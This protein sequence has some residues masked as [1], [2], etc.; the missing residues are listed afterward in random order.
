MARPGGNPGLK[1]FH[2]QQKYDWNEPCTEKIAFRVPPS[3]KSA[4]KSEQLNW[5]EI[6]R[7][8]I[9]DALKEKGVE[10]K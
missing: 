2:F 8:A 9:A 4:I 5:Q 3:M 10:M 6:C 1:K 7:Q